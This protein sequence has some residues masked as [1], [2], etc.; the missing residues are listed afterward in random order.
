MVYVL[1][2]LLGPPEMSSFAGYAY[3]GYAPSIVETNEGFKI[4]WFNSFSNYECIQ[5]L[6]LFL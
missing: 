1:H 4:A 3:M 6:A 2:P 5:C